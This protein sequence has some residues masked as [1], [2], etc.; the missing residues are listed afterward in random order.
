[1]TRRPKSAGEV[2]GQRDPRS[3][4]IHSASRAKTGCW[5]ARDDDST[6]RK[7]ATLRFS[8]TTS[9]ER[10]ERQT[11]RLMAVL[12]ANGVRTKGQPFLMRYND[13]ATPPFMRRNEVA[14]EVE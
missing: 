2:P 12:R 10:V 1:M 14:V 7:L 5:S 11:E 6:P 4:P 13:P 9:R 8:W 3:W